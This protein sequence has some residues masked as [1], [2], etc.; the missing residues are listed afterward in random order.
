MPNS[1]QTNNSVQQ[2]V[3]EIIESSLEGY[4]KAERKSWLTDLATH[5]CISGMVSHLIYYHQ[6]ECFFDQHAD[7]ILEL[8]H[9][10]DFN[11][12]IVEEGRT[13]FK[14]NMAW[15]AFEVLA[16]NYEAD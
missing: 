5:G 2:A 10:L 14:N 12:N 8:A 7:E 3:F 16:A 11:I 1:E 13:Q 4:S 9:L 6:T 15:F